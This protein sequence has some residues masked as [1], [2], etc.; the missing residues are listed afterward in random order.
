MDWIGL[1]QDIVNMGEPV[2]SIKCR[3]II[4]LRKCQV[5]KKS[6]VPWS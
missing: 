1:G 6:F 3:K 4:G 5:P 2:G